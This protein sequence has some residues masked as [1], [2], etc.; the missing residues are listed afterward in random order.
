MAK[1]ITGLILTKDNQ[2]AIPNRL[3]KKIYDNFK[4]KRL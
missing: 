3:Q 2:L 1:D 4:D